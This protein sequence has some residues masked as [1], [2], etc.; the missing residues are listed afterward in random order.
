MNRGPGTSDALTWDNL[1][2]SVTDCRQT[3]S[4]FFF[5]H[6]VIFKCGSIYLLL[7][8]NGQPPNIATNLQGNTV[9]S[10]IIMARPAHM[11]AGGQ[12]DISN[13]TS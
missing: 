5:F 4:I 1:V 12:D 9:T 3:T 11:S 8:S 13:F 10:N 6:S 7:Q 2:S